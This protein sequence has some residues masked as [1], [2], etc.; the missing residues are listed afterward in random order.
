[1]NE[2]HYYENGILFICRGYKNLNF[3][4]HVKFINKRK[5]KYP[6]QTKLFFPEKKMY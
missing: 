1:M 3:E 6:I 2:I 4:K 5:K